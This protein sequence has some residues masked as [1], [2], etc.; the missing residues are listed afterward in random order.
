MFKRQGIKKY[1]IEELKK[2]SPKYQQE[3]KSEY[4]KEPVMCSTCE[5]FLTGSLGR[6]SL[7]CSGKKAFKIAL[8]IQQT[9]TIEL[10]NDFKEHVLSTLRNEDIGVKVKSDFSILLFSSHDF[11]KT[12]KNPE[13]VFQTRISVRR[14]MQSLGA[15]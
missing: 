11:K 7:S 6:H 3:W 9:I 8:Q 14:N 15:L 1:N 13:K 10:S 5:S 2:P 4:N 12:L